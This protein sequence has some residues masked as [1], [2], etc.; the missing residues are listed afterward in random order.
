MTDGLLFDFTSDGGAV[1]RNLPYFPDPKD[2]N[3]KLLNYQHDWLLRNDE[4]A[5]T[6]LW[7]LAEKVAL[8]MI[9]AQEKRKGFRLD[10]DRRRDK[11]MDAL[12][13]VFRRYRYGW[14]VTGAYLQAIKCGVIHALYYRTKADD[15]ELMV[16][17]EVIS[18][19]ITGEHDSEEHIV[20]VEGMTREEAVAR[21]RAE[22][23][24]EIAD[25]LLEEIYIVGGKN[26]RT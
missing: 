26:E 5:K 14:Y 16:E 17:D 25:R 12:V 6:K 1:P 3:Q 2:D 7:V 24:P 22:L 15:L 18:R 9:K 21:I 20:C 4:E 23:L 19:L 11:A 8:R 13:Y 10:P